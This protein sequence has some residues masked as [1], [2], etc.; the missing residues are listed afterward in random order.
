[1]IETDVL[2]V[3]GGPVGLSLALELGLQGRS[4]LLIEKIDRA[5]VAP[6]A[7]TTNV[8]SKELL[9]RW[10]IAG[11]LAEASPFGV[12]YPSNVVFATR[13]SGYE[14][15]RFENGFNCSPLRDDRF[16]E[17]AQWIPQY[18]VEAEL[19]RRVAEFPN[20]TTR[21]STRLESWKEDASGV[22]A[23]LVDDKNNKSFMVR[24]AYIVGADGARS[25]VREQLGIEMEGAS[26]LAHYHNIV[27][28]CKDLAR[29]HGLGPGIMYWLVN[30]EVP[31]VLGPLD[32]D[33][34]WT[35]GCP[36]LADMD[37]DPATLIRVALGLDLE[38]EII[39]RDNWTAHQL[40]A[41]TYRKGRIFLAGDACH[42]H[43]PFGGFGMNMGIGDAVDLGWKLAARLDGWGGDALL[44][45]YSI[46]RRQIH[47]RVVD[48]AVENHAHSS[49]SLVVDG[50]EDEGPAGDAIR[51]FV[52]AQILMHKR[53]E[54]YA[55]GVVLG[56]SIETSPVLTSEPS[57]DNEKWDSA[58]YIPNARPGSLAPHAWLHE[59][60]EQGASLYDHFSV[61][62]MTLLVTRPESLEAANAVILAAEAA[63]V[64]LKLL[65][66]RCDSLNRLYG[67]DMA[68][69]RPDQFVAWRGNNAKD[70]SMALLKAVGREFT[71]ETMEPSL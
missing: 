26:G 43:P 13:L 4:C 11:R 15:A 27:F 49:G 36:K 45:S 67:A 39:S 20:V 57:I 8:R 64:P 33:D 68:L 29:K 61:R 50:I 12:N 35:F 7:K 31:A 48:E 21:M 38:I 14:L 65:A 62:G 5:G 54:F 32:T 71:S 28:R 2:V 10:G 69:I 1:M 17:H 55:L 44:D 40:I 58:T 24:A 52:K 47:L 41:R 30:H 53:R 6:R 66:P 16:S 18:K 3:G 22:T 9:R 19:T 63:G 34:V 56:I 70:A 42:L 25:T 59:G 46:E 23:Q 51:V 60:T 37:A